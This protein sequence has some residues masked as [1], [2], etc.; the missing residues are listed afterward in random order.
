METEMKKMISISTLH[1]LTLALLLVSGT[2]LADE[3]ALGDLKPDPSLRCEITYNFVGHLG[4][5][6]AE[7]RLLAWDGEIHGDIEGVIF[8]WFDLT[9]K[10]VIGQVSHYVARWEILDGDKALLLAGDSAGTTTTPPGK[11]GIWLGKGLVTE[12]SAGFEEWM[13]CEM[14]EGGNVTWDET[15]NPKDGAGRFRVNLV[16]DFNGDGE[17][18]AT[19]ISIMAGFWH[20]DEPLCDIGPTPL[21]DGIVDV[22]D[23]LVLAEYLAQADA[24]DDIRAIEELFNQSTLAIRAGDVELYL[25]AFT[26]DAVVMATGYPPMIGKETLRPTYEGLFGQFDLELPYT[27]HEVGIPGDWAFVRSS[28]LYSMTPK[29]GGETTTSPGKQ[30]DIFKRQADGSWKIYIQCWNYGETPPEAK[31]A[32]TSWG[33]GLANRAQ[34]DDANT[35][36]GEVC[37]MYTLAAETGDIDLYV[38]NYTGDGVQMPPDEPSRIGSE[39]I[40]AVMEP[41]LA[42]FDAKC[43][44]YPQ[45]AEA[46]GDWAFG[47]CDWSLSLT[48]KE[49]G[50]TTTFDGKGLDVLKRQV[51]GSWKYYISCWSYNGPPAVE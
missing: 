22:Q 2:V 14:Y 41:A 51:D 43:P 31:M 7:G 1:V 13:G 36:Y 46:T 42:M 18:D 24:E 21:G 12:A 9:R 15:G 5:F 33:P 34:G 17:V 45:I 19:D 27:V 4:Q 8:W 28:F 10:Q 48:P 30:L 35:M 50:E 38:A 37:D 23:L 11:D 47:T 40:R 20:T 29:E 16:V 32:V 25:S 44:I 26:E 6:D 49:G 39:Q 3:A